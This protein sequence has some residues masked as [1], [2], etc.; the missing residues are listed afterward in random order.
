MSNVRIHVAPPS[1]ERWPVSRQRSSA[2]AGVETHQDAGGGLELPPV[3]LAVQRERDLDDVAAGVGP[4][5]GLAG[6][7]VERR[8]G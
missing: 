6:R 1:V 3:G 4:E 2:A 8:D 7:R 5:P